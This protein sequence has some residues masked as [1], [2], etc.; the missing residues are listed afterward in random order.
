MEEFCLLYWHGPGN[1]LE[2]Y[3]FT[4]KARSNA[5]LEHVKNMMDDLSENGWT[6]V[7][8]TATRGQ[9]MYV[10]KRKTIGGVRVA[11]PPKTVPKDKEKKD[12]KKKKNKGN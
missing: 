2:V 5:F 8:M 11:P 7:D 9:W 4:K 3:P 12:K 10:F 6:F 1:S